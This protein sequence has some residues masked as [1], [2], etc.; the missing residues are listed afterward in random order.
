MKKYFITLSVALSSV[1]NAQVGI[2][3]DE[4]KATL[5]INGDLRIRKT[6]VLENPQ[7]VLSVDE[8]GF[9]KK[10]DVA[11]LGVSTVN[12]ESAKF[13]TS[14]GAS[15][16]GRVPT[17]DLWT[18]QETAGAENIKRYYFLGQVHSVTLPKNISKEGEE[19]A[20]VIT[21]VVV[22]N[23]EFGGSSISNWEVAF[24]TKL[25][26]E[27]TDSYLGT[28]GGVFLYQSVFNG[29]DLGGTYINEGSV[30]GYRRR[31]Y[32]SGEDRIADR[33]IN[34]YDFGGKWVMTVND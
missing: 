31:V 32:M 23:S 27:N 6:E 11:K 22:R 24:Q 25:Y 4:P 13:I 8:E 10:I 5:D 26:Q 18:E 34:F 14:T 9:V 30:N 19:L 17:L 7:H 28:N 15:I 33:E 20:R 2:N 29:S 16:A 21:F 3:T 12:L 1:L